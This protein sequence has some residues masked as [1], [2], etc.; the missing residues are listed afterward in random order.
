MRYTAPTFKQYKKASRFA[1][2]RYEFG[3]YVQVIAAA[4]L[5]YLLFYSITNIEE[6]K[7]NPAEYAEEKLGVMC[8]YPITISS[9]PPTYGNIRNYTSPAWEE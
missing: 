7:A 6:M 8:Y 5:L 4:L 2:F 3:V 9:E 1:R